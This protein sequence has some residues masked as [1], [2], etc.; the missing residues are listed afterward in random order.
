VVA[1]SGSSIE[2]ASEKKVR[3][4]GENGGP[5][6]GA[7]RWETWPNWR[8]KSVVSSRVVAVKAGRGSAGGRESAVGV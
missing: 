7:R 8:P 4:G 5:L 6:V 2:G 3:A 1:S